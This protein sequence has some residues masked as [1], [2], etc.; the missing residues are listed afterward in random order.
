MSIVPMIGNV[1]V[2]S[3]LAVF[4]KI[5]FKAIMERFYSRLIIWSLEKLKSKTSNEVVQ[6]TVDDII[7]SLR[8]K[9]LRVVDDMVK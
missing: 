2:E 7:A 4:G 3:T 5:A 1:I 8:G 6:K 9:R